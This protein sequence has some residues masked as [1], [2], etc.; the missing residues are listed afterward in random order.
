MDAYPG[1]RRMGGCPG[2]GR[3]KQRCG[4]HDDYHP[5]CRQLRLPFPVVALVLYSTAARLGA[6]RGGVPMGVGAGFMHYAPAVF[7]AGKLA[8]RTLFDVGEFCRNF[9]SVYRTAEQAV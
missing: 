5:L 3:R 6:R 1:P 2:V 7:G 8:D 4:A 9:E